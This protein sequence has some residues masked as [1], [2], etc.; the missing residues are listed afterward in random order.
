MNLRIC[1]FVKTFFFLYFFILSYSPYAFAASFKIDNPLKAQDFPTLVE[2]LSTAV[3]KIGVPFAVAA[4]IFGGFRFISATAA[5]NETKL[6][7]AR[8]L[9]I[10]T[11]VG[12]A[13]IVGGAALVYAA[14]NFAKTLG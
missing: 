8:T 2:H 12:T 5:G 10:W 4:L 14:V 7:E 11:I 9:I 6:K 1:K 13:V 3:M